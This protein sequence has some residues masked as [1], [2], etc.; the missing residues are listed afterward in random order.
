MRT[1]ERRFP[2]DYFE[3]NGNGCACLHGNTLA[4]TSVSSSTQQVMQ[5]QQ[6]LQGH[7]EQLCMYQ[8]QHTGQ[9]AS[10]QQSA[11]SVVISIVAPLLLL[12]FPLWM[13]ACCAD[14]LS[15]DPPDASQP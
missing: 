3:L 5:Q 4:I 14:L 6:Q 15:D 11:A 8:Q 13:P 1:D 2:A 9:Y 10:E 7:Q 12:T